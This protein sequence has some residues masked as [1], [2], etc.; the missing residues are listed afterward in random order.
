LRERSDAEAHAAVMAAV[1]P[2]SGGTRTFL[3]VDS[4]LRGPLAGLISGALAGGGL[5]CAVVAPAFPEQGRSVRAGRLHLGDQPGASLLDVLGTD[6]AVVCPSSV[7]ELERACAGGVRHVVVDADT[8]AVLGVVAA[9]A[10][11]HPEWLLVGS[12]GLARQMALPHQHAIVPSVGVGPVL[13]VA[14]SPTA[15]TRAQLEHLAGLRR[16]VLMATPPSDT[17]DAGEA[18][19]ALAERVADW[20]QH[21]L[22]AAVVLTGGA[23]AREVSHHL[24]ASSVRILG[25]IAP[26][27]PLGHFENGAWDGVTVVTKAGGFGTPR[28]LLDV[29]QALGVSSRG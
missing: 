20:A 12:A 13:V 25:E 4:T 26:G 9:A 16:V 29:V 1:R 7:A 27:I 5:R 11:A 15:I 2:M 21:N 19:A 10:S 3:K 23:T 28:T 18:A 6:S 24:G 17:R 8:S 14:G 22:P